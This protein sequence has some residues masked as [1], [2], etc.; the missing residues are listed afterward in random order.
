ME[1]NKTNFKTVLDIGSSKITAIVGSLENSQVKVS[2]F[3][4]A[5]TNFSVSKG[6]V[7]NIE[8]VVHSIRKAVEQARLTVGQ[9]IDRVVVGISGSHIDYINNDGRVSITSD[10]VTQ[11]DKN[12]V[13][14]SAEYTT[15]LQS[16][17]TILHTL[18]QVFNIDGQQIINPVGMSGLRLDV[19]VHLVTALKLPLKNLHRC[20]EKSGL[21]V[22]ETVANP[23]AA[24]YGTTTTRDRENGTIVIDIGAG[25]TDICVV[26]RQAIVFTG[27]IDYGGDDVSQNIANTLKISY[28]HAE[29]IK[30]QYGCASVSIASEADTPI[31]IRRPSGDMRTIY[32]SELATIIMDSYAELFNKIYKKLSDKRVL[33]F[34]GITSMIHLTGGATMIEGC[35]K[36]AEEIF[37]RSSTIIRPVELH[38]K[39]WRDLVDSCNYATTVGLLRFSSAN[40]MKKYSDL[41]SST[42]MIYDHRKSIQ[43][44]ESDNEKKANDNK[45]GKI[46]KVWKWIKDNW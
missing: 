31:S 44:D 32:R 21:I 12:R 5:E 8:E 20:I 22:D 29:E 9:P 38:E 18:P 19:Q 34:L 13:I 40:Q 4:E 41:T 37:S 23:L 45:V 27:V 7:N 43:V 42:T 10:E 1:A 11:N 26:I 24:L 14:K 36:L 33:D 6:I 25:V 46:D 30:K 3:G 35:A 16:E 39:G 28:E 2:G 17:R 15:K